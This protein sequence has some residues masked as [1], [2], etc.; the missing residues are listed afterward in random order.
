MG[1]YRIRPCWKKRM[2]WILLGL[3][4]FSFAVF[5]VKNF[6]RLSCRKPTLVEIPEV[7]QPVAALLEE[8][9]A[10]ENLSVR[11]LYDWGNRYRAWGLLRIPE[12]EPED[13]RRVA[14]VV[15]YIRKHN[16]AL[17]SSEIWRQAAA[18]V[19][20]S[21]KYDISLDFAVAVG[22]VESHFNPRARSPYGAAGVM[23]IMWPVHHRLMKA[24][25][26]PRE[27]SLH[28]PDLGVAAGVLLLSRYLRATENEEEALSRYLGTFVRAYIS[29]VHRYRRILKSHLA[30]RTASANP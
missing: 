29:K 18:F 17:R 16:G 14:L 10:R 25:G 5:P 12:M 19:H 6:S 23:Q 13:Q 26:I 21:R 2:P 28:D 9:L 27:E 3:G 30:P 4:I 7:I 20:Y 1:K 11:D 15:R 24:N 8:E 22:H